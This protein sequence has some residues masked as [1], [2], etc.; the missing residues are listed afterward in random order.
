MGYRKS[1][2]NRFSFPRPHRLD[3][4]IHFQR[5]GAGRLLS[6][7]TQLAYN[8]GRGYLSDG[9]VPQAQKVTFPNQRTCQKNGSHNDQRLVYIVTRG[10]WGW[11]GWRG[12][13]G[14]NGHLLFLLSQMLRFH[15]SLVDWIRRMTVWRVNFWPAAVCEAQNHFFLYLCLYHVVVH[16]DFH[17]WR[18]L[19]GF[20]VVA[21]YS[22]LITIRERISGPPRLAIAILRASLL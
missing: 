15:C 18:C 12:G 19:Y 7:G 4:E 14:R 1:A 2:K 6:C 20:V 16:P 22:V 9:L 3:R 8:S 21:D 17:L 13:G 5:P 10:R 11:A